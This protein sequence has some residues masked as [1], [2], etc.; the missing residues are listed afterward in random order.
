MS[1]KDQGV[2][3]SLHYAVSQS[4]ETFLSLSASLGVSAQLL[5][6]ARVLRAL[7]L[8]IWPLQLG[9]FHWAG[10]GDKEEM[11][12]KSGAVACYRQITLA[13]KICANVHPNPG[14]MRF[15]S[16]SP[17]R[18]VVRINP[19]GIHSPREPGPYWGYSGNQPLSLPTGSQARRKQTSSTPEQREM[20]VRTTMPE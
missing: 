3:P 2:L 17:L 13:Q 12:G 19:F 4:V 11:T 16:P 9:V 20:R 7:H 10:A 5:P 1:G 8:A 6:A 15:H 18:V 14:A